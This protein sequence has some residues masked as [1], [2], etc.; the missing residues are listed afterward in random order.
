MFLKR[1]KI[2]QLILFMSVASLAFYGC[3]GSG[4]GDEDKI[5]PLGFKWLE[6]FIGGE[7]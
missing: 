1:L 7:T 5:F 3:G 4:E 2:N 6:S